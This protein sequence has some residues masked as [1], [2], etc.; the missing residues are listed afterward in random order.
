MT[1]QDNSRTPRGDSA[2]TRLAYVLTGVVLVALGLVA[3]LVLSAGADPVTGKPA[4]NTKPAKLSSL[5]ESTTHTRLDRAPRDPRPQQATE[6]WIVRPTKV[7]AI[8]DAPGG[9]TFGKVGPKQIGETWLPVIAQ[10][11]QWTQVLLPSKPNGST[12]WLRSAHLKREY[13][14]YLIRVHLSSMRL[15]LFFEGREMNS[16]T[17][18]IGKPDTPTPIG[19]TFILGSIVDPNQRYSP[20]ILPLGAHS[21]TLDSFGGGPGTVAIHTWPTTDVLGTASSNGCIR[22]PREA[23]NQLTKVPLGTLVLVDQG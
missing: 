2:S 8:H 14:P 12:G 18:G 16:W 22:V 11:D 21:D 5:V 15:E 7:I 10:R 13:T 6:G 9:R 4:A 20:I 23:L 1:S 3:V 17:I 19:R